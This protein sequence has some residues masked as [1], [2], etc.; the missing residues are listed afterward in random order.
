MSVD[1]NLDGCVWTSIWTP[2]QHGC[3]DTSRCMWTSVRM[4][5]D[6]NTDVCGDQCGCLWTLTWISGHHHGCLDTNR[7]VCGRWMVIAKISMS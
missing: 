7:N 3:S 5:V 1:T 2:H 6:T 4:S